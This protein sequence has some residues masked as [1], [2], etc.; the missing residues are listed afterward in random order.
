[1]LDFIFGSAPSSSMKTNY[2]PQDMQNW[3]GQM[4]P[5]MDQSL[6]L[7][8]KNTLAPMASFGQ[9]I[10]GQIPNAVAGAQAGQ[11]QNFLATLGQLMANSKQMVVNPGSAGILPSMLGGLA[12]GMG[13]PLGEAAGAK[14]F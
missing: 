6:Q 11:M 7:A 3:M 5:Y 1:M 9:G 4:S 2:T 12:S 8:G 13:K 10:S 14:W